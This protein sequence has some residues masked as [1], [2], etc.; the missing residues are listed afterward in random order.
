MGPIGHSLSALTALAGLPAGALALAARSRW[1]PGWRQRLGD[2]RGPTAGGA[3][4]HAASVGEARAARPFVRALID[5]GERVML[6]HTRSEALSIEVLAAPPRDAGRGLAGRSLAPLDHPWCLWR[7]LDRVAPRVI[8]L[9][10]TELWPNAIREASA[11]GIVVGVVSGSISQRSFGRYQRF[12][13]LVRPTFERLGFVAARSDEDA[14]RFRAL[15][16]QE[17]RVRT[18]GDLK[19]DAPPDTAA[20]PPAI[21]TTL[22]DAPLFVA[23]STHEGEEEA[24]LG[25]LRSCRER[26]VAARFVV[27][28]RRAERCRSVAQRVE[29]AGF[30]P[31]L[32]SDW[33]TEPLAPDEVGLIDGP[34]ELP[35]WYGAATVAFVGGTLAPVGG[36]NLYE[37]AERGAFVLH[38]PGVS[39]VS[40][41]A[42]LIAK[43]GAA[44][45]VEDAA[46][47][48]ASAVHWL[49]QPD[50]A[51]AHAARAEPV[52]AAHRGSAAR[53]L[54]WLDTAIERGVAS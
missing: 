39:S 16:V 41:A 38:G 21:A 45:V 29:R 19:L 27:A 48:A 30:R 54:A 53:S 13:P 40:E 25:A 1:R 46:A 44:A 34:G 5:R 15:G 51:A 23:G 32:R 49:A 9:V 26:G 52:L 31:R 20:L 11:R 8:A 7:A 6:T 24:V 47:L 22:G 33:G 10:E 18:T 37:P 35:C 50:R 42:R 36:H 43:A 17:D 14:E 28:P 2:V 12:A 3:W 4:V